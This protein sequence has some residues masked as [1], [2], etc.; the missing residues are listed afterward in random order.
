MKDDFF[1]IV[2]EIIKYGGSTFA[3]LVAMSIYTSTDGFFIG[4]W[5]G[6]EG[7][8]AMA[9]IYPITM[10]FTAL[11]TLFETGGSAVVS[12]KIGEGKK[13]LAEKIM[14]ANY[15]YAMIL[16]VIFVIV[17]NLLIKPL[18]Y[19]I[20]DS[21]EEY[22]IADLA[23]S[24][25][26]ITLCG[27]PFLLMIYL[28]GAFMRCVD[29]PMHVF[30]FIGTTSITNVILDALFIIVFGWGMEG[31]A[32]A[33][34]LAQVLGG[35]VS[36][37]YFRYSEQKFVSSF[38]LGSLKYLIQEF[39]IGIG[40]A[41]GTLMMF[42][43]EFYLNSVLLNYNAAHL[44]AILTISNIILSL[45]YLPLN[46]LDTGIQPLISRLYGAKKEHT[47]LKVMRYGF[48]LTMILTFA[49]YIALM[50]FTEEVAR[51]FVAEN[52]PITPEMILF[53]RFTFL[54]QPFVG[55]YTWLVGIMAA[56]E[57]EWRNFV[58]SLTPLVAQV[59]FIWLLPKFLPIEYVALNYSIQDI[60][61]ALVAFLLIRPFL[62]EKG[63]SFRKIFD[64]R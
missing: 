1:S 23:I 39:K 12:E 32:L 58:V 51:I 37:W 46:G 61:E 29:R 55:I 47:Y 22:Q 20:V 27:L 4:N 34:F 41:V 56:L 59:P 11:G 53:L 52:E 62:K 64:L 19:S 28:T 25:L 26:R 44:L 10:I 14:R 57:D 3:A 31:A 15:V 21:P 50:I 2:T 42:F 45:V 36:F 48:F 13:Q 16:G 49:M 24:F 5:V 33:T 9:L 7:L 17:G 60:A 30:Y 43:I 6:A 63:L 8:E 54:L 18:L 35:V 40:F 38:G